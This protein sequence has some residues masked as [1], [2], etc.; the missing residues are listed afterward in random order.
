MRTNIG[1]LFLNLIKKHFENQKLS[2]IF[3]RNTVKISYSCMKN[4]EAIIKSHNTK[5]VKD[6]NTT[7]QRSCNCARAPC[8]LAGQCLTPNIVYKAT[9]LTTNTP[10]SHPPPTSTPIV[11][12]YI[13]ASEKFKDRYHNHTKSF[14]HREYSKDTELSKFIWELK[15]KNISFDIKWEIMKKTQGYNKISKSCSLCLAEKFYICYF[16]DKEKLLNK[17]NELVSKCRHVN[18][19][20]LKQFIQTS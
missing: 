2:K 11:K 19:H 10:D 8:P 20:L 3:N 13:G 6:T 18:K 1:R 12:I 15:D 16:R 17:R 7:T 14:R 4:M 9:V 5:L